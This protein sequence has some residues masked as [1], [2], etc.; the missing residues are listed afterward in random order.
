[1]RQLR[2]VVG[3]VALLWLLGLGMALFNFWGLP[4]DRGGWLWFLLVAPPAALALEA[5]G[6]LY[7]S[8]W[9]STALA[10]T[11]QEKTKHRRFSWLRVGVAL[12]S[13]SVGFA[14]VGAVLWLTRN[15]F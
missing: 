10:Q 4:R 9:Q 13:V 8:W 3:V 14:L 7:S 12:L 1:M 2:R 5:L 6:E 11:V 15:S